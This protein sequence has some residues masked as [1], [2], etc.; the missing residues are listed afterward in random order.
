M[1]RQGSAQLLAS[2]REE[3][4]MFQASL[5][6]TARPFLKRTR[7]KKK[8]RQGSPSEP[9]PLVCVFTLSIY[10][11]KKKKKPHEWEVYWI[12]A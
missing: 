6:Y 9:Y 2:I 10:Q 8:N 3:G 5:D 7:K 11:K 12:G 1:A 4:H